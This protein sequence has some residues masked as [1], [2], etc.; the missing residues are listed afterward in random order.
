MKDIDEL[1]GGPDAPDALAD[2]PT[3]GVVDKGPDEF[4]DGF[5]ASPRAADADRLDEPLESIVEQKAETYND[6]FE[7]ASDR[8][9][10]V[11]DDMLAA[12]SVRAM[13]AYEETSA[14]NATL[15]TWTLGRQNEFLEKQANADQNAGFE[16]D[17]SYTQDDDLAPRG[18][19][20]STLED[21]E[22]NP[23]NG[24]DLR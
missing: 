4:R 21:D 13:G 19:G 11:T 8:N 6:R 23:S 14:P 16:V 1:F 12:V 7:D 9:D 10:R 18:F 5:A 17:D 3:E 15:M 24:P 22:V 2:T 20:H